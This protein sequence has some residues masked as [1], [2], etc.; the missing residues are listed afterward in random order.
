MIGLL[1]SAQ[2]QRTQ[3]IEP[4][5]RWS[6]IN[7]AI[8]LLTLDYM[9]R[10]HEVQGVGS[11]DPKPSHAPSRQHWSKM[12]VGFGAHGGRGRCF[13]LWQDFLRCI[14]DSGKVS[15]DI[16]QNQREDYLECLHHHKL[17]RGLFENNLLL[18]SS[19]SSYSTSSSSLPPIPPSQDDRLRA[20]QKQK[21]KLIREGKWPP[22][23]QSS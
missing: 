22:P 5:V 8:S 3:Y 14:S 9:E 12:V 7:P 4:G 18:P 19:F 11:R 17:V 15:M 2:R 13:L 6:W 1:V 20:I 16:C 23:E 21:A 10:D